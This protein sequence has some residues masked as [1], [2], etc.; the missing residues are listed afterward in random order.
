M[1]NPV[2]TTEEKVRRIQAAWSSLSRENL[3]ALEDIYAANLRFEDPLT[4]GRGLE[5]LRQHFRRIF[6]N[7]SHP[8]YTYRG[9]TGTS[10]SIVIEWTLKAELRSSGK[11]F[12]LPGISWLKLNPES[13]KIE[14][15]REYFDLG[16]ALYEQI[17]VLGFFI[18]IIRARL[19][20]SWRSGV[21]GP[22]AERLRGKEG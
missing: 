20:G 14:E 21:K 19:A 8:A 16:K 6:R 3:G 15:S 2:G 11:A 5:N 4:T 10:G 18:K 1:G 12:E 17:P 9:S 7:L 22:M 13:G